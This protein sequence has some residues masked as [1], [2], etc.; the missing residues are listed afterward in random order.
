MSFC[1]I[2]RSLGAEAFDDHPRLRL[3]CNEGGPSRPRCLAKMTSAA[4]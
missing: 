3:M 1:A 4:I 2:N